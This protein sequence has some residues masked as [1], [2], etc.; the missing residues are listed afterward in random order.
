MPF[1]LSTK[2]EN[3][4]RKSCDAYI[5]RFY[6][7][8]LFF[9]SLSGF[10]LFVLLFCAFL[11]FLLLFPPPSPS[12]THT[13]TSF[14][15]LRFLFFFVRNFFVGDFECC[16][17]LS[18]WEIRL[19]IVTRGNPRMLLK[20]RE[21]IKNK[22]ATSKI[23]ELTTKPYRETMHWRCVALFFHFNFNSLYLSVSVSLSLSLFLF[24]LLLLLLLVLVLV[25]LVLLFLLLFDTFTLCQC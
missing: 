24:P 10:F 25:L 5:E 19:W 4:N 22:K 9:L 23:Q 2:I 18:T 3:R 17:R 6:F 11:H 20:A 7:P 8:F 21:N 15:S 1:I 13:Y 16:S 12:H 14:F